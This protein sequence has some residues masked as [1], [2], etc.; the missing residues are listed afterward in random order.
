M[1]TKTE[2]GDKSL[3]KWLSEFILL[4]FN[5]SW[6]AYSFFFMFF[7]FFANFRKWVEIDFCNGFVRQLVLCNGSV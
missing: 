3:L 4:P 5:D 1:V 7:K 6:L 2:D